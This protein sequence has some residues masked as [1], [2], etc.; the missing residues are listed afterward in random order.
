MRLSYLPNIIT[1][2][3]ISM[4]PVLILLLKERHYEAALWTFLLAGVSDGIDGYVAKRF[5]CTSQLGAVLDPIA[6]KLLLVSVYVM[7]TLQDI[8]PFWLLLCVAF[9]D[10]LI[11]GGYVVYVTLHAQVQMRPSYLSKL[12]TFM[13]ITLALAALLAESWGWPGQ[14]W[15]HALIPAVFVT[16]LA[17]GA[18]YLW[19]WVVK[20]EIEPLAGG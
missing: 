13:Q 10:L 9:R 8:I 6:D 4:V 12:N 1:L 7:L 17:S 19:L 5:N 18:H 16:T 11:V 20:G 2:F 15:L 14:G 3:R